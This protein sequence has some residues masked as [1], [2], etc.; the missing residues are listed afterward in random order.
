M[1]ETPESYHEPVL[2][3][4]SLELLSIQPEGVYVDATFGGGGHSKAILN[5]LGERGRVLAF[6]QD[7]DVLEY[8]PDDDRLIFFR[9][10]YSQMYDQLKSVEIEQVDGILADLGV[11]LHQLKIQ[12][13]GFSFRDGGPLDMRMSTDIS[14]T[15]ADVLNGYSASELAQVLYQFGELRDARRM[16]RSIV[17]RREK[18]PFRMSQ[19]LN[20]AVAPF[21]PR[22]REHKT[23]AQLYQALRIEVN[24]EMDHLKCFLQ[25]SVALLK[26]GGCMAVIS[27]HSLEDRMVKLFFRTG[28]VEGIPEKDFYGNLLR[29]LRPLVKKP[30][31]PSEQEV[32]ANPRAR[33]ARLRGAVRLEGSDM[34]WIARR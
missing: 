33:S 4:E 21:L 1:H 13:R 10:N 18:Y 27:Y 29:P 12:G 7:S 19:D 34:Q 26:Q 20:E 3:T 16:A 11:S 9:T 15:A 6:D 14:I 28:N 5:H 31:R 23:L 25:Q 22:F 30:I 2:V 8:V 32:S 17:N 24:Q